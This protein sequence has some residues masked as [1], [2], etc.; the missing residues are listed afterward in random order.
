MGMTGKQ[1]N[2]VFILLKQRVKCTFQPYAHVY[3]SYILYIVGT[4]LHSHKDKDARIQDSLDPQGQRLTIE[5]YH[6]DA[7]HC[8]WGGS[9]VKIPIKCPFSA[10]PWGIVVQFSASTHISFDATSGLNA[11]DGEDR[12]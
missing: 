8:K 5:R 7:I 3:Q 11:R 10:P 9:A 12:I 2:V 1:T 6:G 4:L